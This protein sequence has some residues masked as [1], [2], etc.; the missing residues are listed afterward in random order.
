MIFHD[1]VDFA[2]FRKIFRQF[3]G[4][5]ESI[6]LSL[7]CW[8]WRFYEV[9]AFE[10]L[11][12][13]FMLLKVSDVS[14]RVSLGNVISYT[15][16]VLHSSHFKALHLHEKQFSDSVPMRRHRSSNPSL[17]PTIRP[18]NSIHVFPQWMQVTLFLLSSPVFF[19]FSISLIT[20]VMSKRFAPHYKPIEWIFMY[21]VH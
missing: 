18:T 19:L 15:S 14:P 1:V 9:S 21:F 5:P 4:A 6:I 11:V 20:S 8:M 17:C 16:F 3:H 10:R 12:T 2:V 7:C 13:F